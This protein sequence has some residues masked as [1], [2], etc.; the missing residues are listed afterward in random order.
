MQLFDL[1][2]TPLNGPILI[3]ASAGT[4]KTYTI[5]GLFVRL[6]IERGLNVDQIL[7]VT[8][9]VAA[10][11]ELKTRIR[12]RLISARMG[13]VRE[14]EDDIV[15]RLTAS[16]TDRQSAL[17]R[18]DGAL[19]DFDRAAIS[20]IHGFCQRLLSENTFETGAPF[21]TVLAADPSGYYQEVAEDFWRKN[22]YTA[23]PEFIGFL[24]NSAA[25][26]GPS[27]FQR[28]LQNI[29]IPD[30]DVLPR[31]ARPKAIDLDEYRGLRRRLENEWPASRS[32]VVEILSDPVLNAKLYGR[33]QADHRPPGRTGREA[34][35]QA[36]AAAMDQFCRSPGSGFFPPFED[37]V[38]FTAAHLEYATKKGCSPPQHPFFT[39]CGRLYDAAQDLKAE[40]GRYW[41]YLKTAF[42]GYARTELAATKRK[43]GLQFYDDLLLSVRGALAA[44]NPGRRRLI[45]SVQRRFKTALVDEFQDTDSI[46]YDI[47]STLFGKPPS[48]LFMIGDPKQSIY[49]FRGADIFSYM[50]AAAHTANRYT[51]T[52]NWRSDPALI[53]AVN[54]LFSSVDT[55]FLYKDIGFEKG[56]AGTGRTGRAP[57][58]LPALSLWFLSARDG[59]AINKTEA[60]D[61]IAAAVGDEIV[62]LM[63]AAD[64]RLA[65]EDI[66]VLVRTNRQARMVKDHLTRRQVPAVI[67]GAG[68]IFDTRE[69]EEIQRI[70]KGVTGNAKDERFRAALVTDM[71]G[72]RSPELDAENLAPLDEYRNRFR[73]YSAIWHRGGFMPMFQHLMAREGVRARILA[74]TDGD[75]RLT[76]I[77]QLAEILHHFETEYLSGPRDLLKWLT[78]QRDPAVPRPE[79][80]PL[81]LESD[82]RAVCIVTV[83]KSKGLEYPVVFCPFGW[84]GSLARKNQEIICH[85]EGEP[86]GRI[87][88]LGSD[89]YDVHHR[90]AQEENLAENLRLLY[91][92]LTRARSR[93]YLVWG[94]I[95]TAETSALAY[96]LHQPPIDAGEDV[97]GRLKSHINK[98]ADA[99]LRADLERLVER[100]DGSIALME[101]PQSGRV[102]KTS[103][104]ANPVAISCRSFGGAIDTSWKISS[105]TSLANRREQ[106]IE[107][108]DRDA[109]AKPAM[110]DPSGKS[111]TIAPPPVLAEMRRQSIHDF[112]TGA[113]A[114]IF[115]HALLEQLDFTNDDPQ[116]RDR[117][118]RDHLRG[119]GFDR[120]WLDVVRQTVQRVMDVPLLSGENDLTLSRIG[121]DTRI[122]EMA[123]YYPLKPFSRY[124]LAKVF[125]HAE[126]SGRIPKEFPRLLEKLSFSPSGGYLKGYV[127][128]VFQHQERYYL[129]DWKS[130]ALGR[131]P[132][133]YHVDRLRTVMSGSYYIL[134]YCLYA[135]A[136]TRYL[137]L[138]QPAFDFDENFGGVF[139]VFLRGIDPQEGPNYGIYFD[140][141]ELKLIEALERCL[142]GDL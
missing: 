79:E 101:M 98:A 97:V 75:R 56:R 119:H 61:W 37:L 47:F 44:E 41:L 35:V 18:I 122:N 32:D 69:A 54:T 115:F 10:T 57:E 3:E 121:P 24:M 7:V 118:I 16:L 128:L 83:H 111:D 133:D 4:G 113:H 81:R 76:N 86:K 104:E 2:D 33:L 38:K 136:L 9:T 66:A 99:D 114:G 74:F 89:R 140:R 84:E 116:Y 50:N 55:P 13:L 62:R 125:A 52:E 26:V 14:S 120:Q 20:T 130:N 1:I 25:G 48:I 58:P 91:V 28:L 11:Q 31:L 63:S 106:D 30:I 45:E 8:Y 46:Q 87:L 95:N 112:P 22:F 138:R 39:L 103:A 59:R 73:E 67:Y 34:K 5:S 92:A 40:M 132:D 107:L 134:Q 60:V 72:V 15:S 17:K 64:Q 141:P 126:N 93:C 102:F 139:Y 82:H 124:Q 19:A 65:P 117:L 29:H 68:D 100:S 96:L 49:S 135:L 131:Q 43:R 123:F 88:D 21:D 105:Y 23:E 137:R 27:L 12:Q 109:A 90:Q 77:L 127:D 85:R 36:L 142:V 94:R 129:L 110:L 51:L 108:P 70:L 78:G 80:H 6:I 71:L 42:V 53:K